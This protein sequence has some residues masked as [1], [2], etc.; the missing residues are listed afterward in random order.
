MAATILPRIK[1]KTQLDNHTIELQ[2]K[3]N[4]QFAL[5][6]FINTYD[7]TG[8]GSFPMVAFSYKVPVNQKIISYEPGAGDLIYNGTPYP[9]LSSDDK[10]IFWQW[11]DKFVAAC[12]KNYDKTYGL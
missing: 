8:T 9:S 6:N 7:Y 10:V 5:Y 12:I 3:D 1:G 4:R 2:T 11:I